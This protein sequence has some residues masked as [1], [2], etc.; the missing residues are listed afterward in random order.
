MRDVNSFPSTQLESSIGDRLNLYSTSDFDANAGNHA[1]R[2]HSFNHSMM[3]ER[4]A[5]LKENAH[6]V[7]A[8]HL[9]L[10]EVVHSTPFDLL[11]RYSVSKATGLQPDFE[12]EDCRKDRRKAV[13]L[14][15]P[16]EVARY[17]D[18]MAISY[19]R[20]FQLQ[21]S[22]IQSSE[23]PLFSEI[24]SMSHHSTSQSSFSFDSSNHH[25]RM[26]S[27]PISSSES[28]HGD[29]FLPN[30]CSLYPHSSLTF[31][32]V[33]SMPFN[34]YFVYL[35]SCVDDPLMIPSREEIEQSPIHSSH[36]PCFKPKQERSH[37]PLPPEGLNRKLPYACRDFRNG[38]CT[39]GEKCRFM[40]VCDG[41]YWMSQ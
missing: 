1:I 41:T 6:S 36:S 26:Y 24:E 13:S 22:T 2:Q 33:D 17:T 10:T 12:F 40:H 15:Q 28:G 18:G 30:A 29:L 39:R 4:N 37:H 5:S 19:P 21:E 20:H 3:Y 27:S 25:L 16:S 31:H 11:G 8:Y 14:L 38:Q 34:G 7:G 23:P 32:H 35:T 9:D